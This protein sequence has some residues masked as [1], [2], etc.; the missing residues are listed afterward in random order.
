MC[1]CECRMW[2]DRWTKVLQE[3]LVS[4][5]YAEHSKVPPKITGCFGRSGRRI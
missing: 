2:V 4:G 1:M 3:L 5:G